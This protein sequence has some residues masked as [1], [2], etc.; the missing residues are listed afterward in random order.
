MRS[1]RPIPL[2]TS[3][4]SAPGLL[5]DVGDLVDERDLGRQEGVRGELDHLGA[6]DVGP[7]QRRLEG[8]VELDDGVARPA[9]L[10]ADDDPVGV[11]EVL[12]RR[13][14]LQELGAGDV[15]E[16]ALALL[17]EDA[18]QRGA[19]C[20]RGPS[21]SSP[22]RARASRGSRRRR[23]GRPTGR[24]RRSRSAGCRR[25]RTA[26][27]RARAR[28]RCRSRSAGA[29]G[30]APAARPAPARRSAPRRRA[31]ARP[32]RRRC[33]RTR[34]R[35]PARRSRRPSPAR[36]SRSRSLRLARAPRS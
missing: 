15:G 18:L 3:T 36:H 19:R 9:A 13:A 5:A 16:P 25:R 32:S 31:G 6:G 20:R 28:R 8:R 35:C 29:R 14:L 1:S 34:P 2:A 10:V 7:H 26:A 21:T 22:A 24:R 11:Q 23:R 27:G 30:C 17:A 12:D 4:T 33:R